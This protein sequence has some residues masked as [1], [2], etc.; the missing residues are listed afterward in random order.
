MLKNSLTSRKAMW[1]ASLRNFIYLLSAYN[2]IKMVMNENSDQLWGQLSYYLN[3]DW[4]GNFARLCQMLGEEP[5]FKELIKRAGEGSVDSIIAG[6]LLLNS[7][8]GNKFLESWWSDNLDEA[9]D[10]ILETAVGG[11]SVYGSF[12]NKAILWIGEH[13]KNM[14]EK[15][16]HKA[17]ITL[18][19]YLLDNENDQYRSS[20][21][22]TLGKLSGS[23]QANEKNLISDDKTRKQ[24]F[25][26]YSHKDKRWLELMHTFLKPYLRD[27]Q[28]TVWDDTKLQPGVKWKE[29]I[30]QALASTKVAVLLVS[31]NF[32]AS[33]FITIQEL[34]SLFKGPTVLWVAVSACLYQQ[35][36]I[37]D[38]QALYD[39]AQPLDTLR[40]AKRNQVLTAIA[41]KI[42]SAAEANDD[43]K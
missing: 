33:D 13:K 5:A 7:P 3:E 22:S 21:E 6:H 42:W 15:S 39:P 41:T 40:P 27:Y 35:T 14:P 26:S 19:K 30:E 37:I 4:D 32:L 38:Y 28:L 25:I 16:A 17:A 34:P 2:E 9:L 18:E 43:N 8:M 31:A 1:L 10:T 24:I 12:Q 11:F 36:P 20:I 29:E 23:E